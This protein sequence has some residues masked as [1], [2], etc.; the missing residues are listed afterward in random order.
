MSPGKVTLA[1]GRIL[2]FAVSKVTPGDP[3]DAY[4][5]HIEAIA[6]THLIVLERAL[7]ERSTLY[8][9]PLDHAKDADEEEEA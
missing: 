4:W 3:K 9:S 8:A 5:A 7:V 6:L 1:D 2:V